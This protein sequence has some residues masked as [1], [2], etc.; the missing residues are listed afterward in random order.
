MR[1]D[2]FHL[3]GSTASEQAVLNLAL[4]YLGAWRP[5]D[6]GAI[7]AHCRPGALRDVEDLSDIAYAL[8]RARIESGVPNA[9]LDE[10]ESFFA[11]ACARISELEAA[12]LRL[13]GKSYLTR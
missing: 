8:T 13:A 1:D 5:A 12:P 6:L 7:P 9:R 3:I 2:Y 4:R 10:M 11:H